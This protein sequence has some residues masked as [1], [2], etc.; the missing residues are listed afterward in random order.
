MLKTGIFTVTKI[1]KEQKHTSVGER[2]NK[3]WYLQA[4]EY[5]SELKNKGASKPE[6]ETWFGNVH[7]IT[8]WKRP[9]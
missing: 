8:K 3:L 5:Y 4:M 1:W 6:E 7:A 9:T 2:T